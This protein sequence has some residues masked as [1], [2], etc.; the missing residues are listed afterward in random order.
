MHFGDALTLLLYALGAFLIPLGTGRVGLPAAV[1]AILAGGGL[2]P[3]VAGVMA[4]AALTTGRRTLTGTLLAPIEV[5]V[6]V[7][8]DRGVI[9]GR[10]YRNGTSASIAPGRHR[11]EVF[12]GERALGART[13]RFTS[14]RPCVLRDRPRWSCSKQ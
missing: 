1:G 14:G 8:G 2:G 10:S 6:D 11:V 7:S 4:P 3:H 12:A 9:R 13:V 5:T